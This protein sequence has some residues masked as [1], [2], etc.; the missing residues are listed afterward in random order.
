MPVGMDGRQEIEGL[1]QAFIL[2]PGVE[3]EAIEDRVFRLGRQI[4]LEDGLWLDL[5]PA[6][7]VEVDG[8]GK[9]IRLGA[10]GVG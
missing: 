8:E 2:I 7:A 4:A 1:G 6:V 3:G 5:G 10:G 9:P